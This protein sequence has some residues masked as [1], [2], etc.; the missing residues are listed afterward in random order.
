M[1]NSVIRPAF[2]LAELTVVI[3]LLLILLA[4]ALPAW[5]R[6]RSHARSVVCQSQLRQV[7]AAIAAYAGDNRGLL[8]PVG[9]RL[10]VSL[11]KEW[12]ELLFGGPRPTVVVCPSADAPEHLSYMLNHWLMIQEVRLGKRNLLRIPASDVVVAGE[13]WPG[14]ND[15][16]RFIN[17]RLDEPPR[18]AQI[19]GSNH[20][21]LDFHVS[22]QPVKRQVWPDPWFIPW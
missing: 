13:N 20:L 19:D 1:S 6:A 22:R 11:A 21:W 16:Y 5:S 8:I 18:H 17:P 2:V 9:G 3:G 4:F 14:T 10:N 7:G 15:D 12:P